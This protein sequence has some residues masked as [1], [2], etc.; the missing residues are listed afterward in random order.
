MVQQ[1]QCG[2]ETFKMKFTNNNI[3]KIH[4]DVGVDFGPRVC[5]HNVGVNI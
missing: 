2:Q 5:T 4:N 1:H 3:M